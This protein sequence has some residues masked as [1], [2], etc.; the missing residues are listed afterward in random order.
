MD[1]FTP[2][3]DKRR[4]QLLGEAWL[5][6]WLENDRSMDENAGSWV[7]SLK[8]TEHP[9]Y[10][11]IWYHPYLADS[12]HD[13]YRC[14]QVGDYMLKRFCDSEHPASAFWFP[15]AEALA[16]ADE[17]MFAANV[18]EFDGWRTIAQPDG[19]PAIWTKV[20]PQ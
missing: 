3:R 10:T 1:K 18:L 19:K 20:K 8:R 5:T 14:Q 9:P 11:W 16:G 6:A 4:G 2:E 15:R 12:D 7:D 17:W 13:V